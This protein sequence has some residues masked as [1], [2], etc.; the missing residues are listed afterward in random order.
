[1]MKI[2]RNHALSTLLGKNSS[3]S[4]LR[5]N[6]SSLSI[7]T[8][9]GSTSDKENNIST[10]GINNPPMLK[11]GTHGNTSSAVASTLPVS[12]EPIISAIRSGNFLQLSDADLELLIRELTG[13]D[14]RVL[15]T[16]K[17]KSAAISSTD[18]KLLA[19]LIASSNAANIKTLK[20]DRSAISQD[21][22]KR[23]FEAL[24]VNKTIT[25][26]GMSRSGVND[27]SIKYIAKSLTKNMALKELDLSN[28]RISSQGIEVLCEV[29]ISNQYLTRLCIQSNNI[30]AAGA[31]H[32]ATLL[33]KNRI[34]RHINVGSNGLGSEGCVMIANAVRF[35]TTL[36]SLSMDMNEMGPRGAS[37]IALVIS[38]NQA[39]THLYIP[40][41][42]IGDEGMAEICTSL[43]RNNSLIGLDVELNHIGH[44]QGTAGMKALAEALTVNT[45]LREIN[46]SYNLLSSEAIQEL[47]A[48]VGANSI[49]ESIL[50]TN[51]CMNTESAL[52]IANV[53]PSATGLQNLGLT[54]NPD[55][56]VD[57]YWALATSL[58]KN[59]SMKG[60]QLDYNSMDRHVLYE[61]IQ[62]SLTRN[63]HW[64]LAVYRSACHLLALSRIVLLG[65]PSEQRLLLSQQLQQQQQ[66]GIG[67]NILK[68]V[69]VE[70]TLSAD[71]QQ[72]LF[73]FGKNKPYDSA[74]SNGSD[75]G[76]DINEGRDGVQNLAHGNTPAQST[77]FRGSS[78]KSNP[79]DDSPLV[80][81]I[82]NSESS[83]MSQGLS[84][85]TPS[86]LQSPPTSSSQQQSPLCYNAHSVLAHL[87]NMPY[88]IF[89]TICA[90]VDSDRNLTIAQ[91]RATIQAGGDRSTLSAHYT[92]AKMLERVL[93]R[94]YIPSVGVRYNIKD[95]EER[96]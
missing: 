44:E 88:E 26:L 40:H 22:I 28:N 73:S 15:E 24:K 43:K 41:N 63:F 76:G 58:E 53:L 38:M 36:N 6:A 78:I 60:I 25:E 20:L 9:N 94:R 85:S 14:S 37:A 23:L 90:F 1:M 79:A 56:E 75:G 87:G 49:L 52:A 62:K 51:C 83:L 47:A 3:S 35:N 66:G 91:I 4:R 42:N 16:I 95:E 82:P 10:L 50:F 2:T 33:T 64:Q 57:G 80:R 81:Q 74:L 54:S 39:L 96:I 11:T 17:I 30:K 21:A 46:L 59:R 12:L 70:R 45:S 68:R 27:K 48:G 71:S 31:R 55:I 5:N 67:S 8:L 13:K 65:H 69:G 18:A 34:I 89:E 61:S 93:R 77:S 92:K 72:A 86:R 7:T 32:L 19:K 84:G 29:L